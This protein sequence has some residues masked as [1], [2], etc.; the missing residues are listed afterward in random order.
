MDWHLCY[1]ER[2]LL[3]IGLITNDW[4]IEEAKYYFIWGQVFLNCWT[5]TTLRN[6]LVSGYNFW[7]CPLPISFCHVCYS[8]N[9]KFFWLLGGNMAPPLVEEVTSSKMMPMPR[10]SIGHFKTKV[11]FGTNFCYFSI[12]YSRNKPNK[13]WSVFLPYVILYHS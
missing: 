10:I 1:L 7:A 13:S 12:Q 3:T 9:F 8:I 11:P 5:G 6:K 2:E 4:T